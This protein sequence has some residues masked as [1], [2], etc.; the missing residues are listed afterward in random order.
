[1][2]FSAGETITFNVT[3][4]AGS[5]AP[6]SRLYDSAGLFDAGNQLGPYTFRYTYVNNVSDRWTLRNGSAAGV[7]PSCTPAAS[8]TTPSSQTNNVGSSLHQST[9]QVT[10]Q[11]TASSI[12]AMTNTIETG[13][14]GQY[15]GGFAGGGSSPFG[16]GVSSSDPASPQQ[17]LTGYGVTRRQAFFM[18]AQ[19]AQTIV[20]SDAFSGIPKNQE[21]DGDDNKDRK[22]TLA[23]GPSSMSFGSNRP[24]GAFLMGSYSG[25]GS[26]QAGGQF[27][28]SVQNVT[29][30]ADYKF[31]P[32][33]LAGLGLGY[34]TSSI[35]TAYNFGSLKG[36]GFTVMPYAAWRQ[37]N[38]QVDAM[39]GIGSL[40]YKIAQNNTTPST[41]S[42][43][44]QRLSFK[45]NL[46]ANYD[47][48]GFHLAPTVGLLGTVEYD[49]SYIDST[50][51]WQPSSSVRILRP[52][53]GGEIGY[54]WTVPM[55]SVVVGP[56]GKALLQYDILQSG[57][58]MLA[59]GTLASDTTL[60]GVLG[61]GARLRI[62]DYLSA[63][64]EG[65][66]NTVGAANISQWVTTGEVR[67]DLPF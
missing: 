63:M 37:D 11:S 38:L 18:L 22:E 24:Y 47:V 34:E 12:T 29:G 40:G 1:M 44:A 60:S 3:A 35:N 4:G 33:L 5:G 41:G 51:A 32:D 49:N 57:R 52:S 23:L 39:V 45:T 64:I 58:P 67:V 62:T 48:D 14:A 13:I 25:V 2:A 55:T 65:T 16:G 9:K 43:S 10:H 61:G 28:G 27:G 19:A 8:A 42:Y 30:G 20:T 66:Y 26:S 54:D 36:S 46:T 50:G 15:G 53:L 59:N 21:K 56:Y 7:V 6:Q 17:G 31:T